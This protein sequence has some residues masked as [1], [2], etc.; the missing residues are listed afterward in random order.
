MTTLNILLKPLKHV[1]SS[2]SRF[3]CPFPLLSSSF[4][5]HFPFLPLFSA[6]PL[7]IILSLL[8]SSFLFLSLVFLPRL[9]LCLYRT[10]FRFYA[11]CLASTTHIK[12]SILLESYNLYDKLSVKTEM[13]HLSL[14]LLFVRSLFPPIFFLTFSF[15][16]LFSYLFL[17][18]IYRLCR[19]PYFL[20]HFLCSVV[21]S[22]VILYYI[23]FFLSCLPLSPSPLLS[24]YL[25]IFTPFP[26][27]RQFGFCTY[28]RL[29][30][31]SIKSAGNCSH[32][33]SKSRNDERDLVVRGYS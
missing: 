1:H 22:W 10:Y 28:C 8:L 33:G 30:T 6:I 18:F 19:L 12:Y 13:I 7:F 11:R 4:I 9:S 27:Q 24:P 16:L 23:P 32:Y 14:S 3:L 26:F 15:C 5:C 20:P 29:Q 2:L 17:L 21:L 31:C 25:S